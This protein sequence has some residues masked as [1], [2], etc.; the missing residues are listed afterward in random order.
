MFN[1]FYSFIICL[2]GSTKE[3]FYCNMKA[4]SDDFLLCSR[5]CKT[6]HKNLNKMAHEQ[7]SINRVLFTN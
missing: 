1:P 7:V 6:G 5:E 3:I 2:L 4:F